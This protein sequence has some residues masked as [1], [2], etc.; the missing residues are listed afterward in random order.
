MS[1]ILS[2]ETFARVMKS[3]GYPIITISDLSG[4]LMTETQF[5]DIVL[6]DALQEYFSWFPIEDKQE[7]TIG[8]NFEI[9]FP[10]DDVYEVVDY[11]LVTFNNAYAGSTGSPFLDAVQTS[12]SSSFFSGK[13]M[14][15]TPYHYNFFEAASME[16]TARQSVVDRY[17]TVNLSV[18]TKN[19][20]VTGYTNYQ[21]RLNITW[22]KTSEDFEDDVITKVPLGETGSNFSIGRNNIYFSFSKRI[23]SIQY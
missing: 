17:R 2:D 9:D 12:Q 21:G 14:Y 5:K 7:Y 3:M 20:K 10:S 22:A 4:G 6:Y 13:K 23:K 1:L 16:R 8:T 11:R 18:D 19:R 15:G